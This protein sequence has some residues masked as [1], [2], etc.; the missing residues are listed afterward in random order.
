MFKHKLKTM[1]LS[2]FVTIVFAF[3]GCIRLKYLSLE[4]QDLSVKE[5]VLVE[6]ET[7]KKNYDYLYFENAEK[8]EVRKNVDYEIEDLSEYINKSLTIWY[9]E[10]NNEIVKINCL[11]EELLTFEMVQQGVKREVIAM[12]SISAVS[13]AIGLVVALFENKLNDLLENAYGRKRNKK[14]NS[15]NFED[16]SIKEKY[17]LIKNNI[18]FKDNK[19]YFENIDVLEN[20]ITE[21]IMEKVLL[22][23]LEDNELRLIY[24]E[25][26]DEKVIYLFYKS[27]EKLLYELL[28][29]DEDKYYE[30]D[31][32][33]FEWSFPK[34]REIN[35]NEMEE[36]KSKIRDF[37]L[38]NPYTL[39]IKEQE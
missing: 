28:F 1:L 21:I 32:E 38:Y 11:D 23:I 34:I 10:N 3:L 29:E 6:I 35:S 22:D 5:V 31:Y 39:K 37:M 15:I 27:N 18:F 17:N 16:E 30:V 14:I 9:F 26:D 7:D 24:E 20:D 25:T 36:I 13:L 4:N 33:Y 12:F 8:M 19:Y 2:L